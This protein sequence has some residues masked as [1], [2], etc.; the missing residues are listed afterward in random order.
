[1]KEAIETFLERQ[2]QYGEANYLK[3]GKVLAMLFPEGITAKGVEDM[4]RL[5]LFVMLVLKVTRYSENFDRGGHQDSVHDLGV[6]A[7]ILEA[8]DDQMRD[9]VDL[10]S[11]E[12]ITDPYWP[13]EET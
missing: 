4:N 2:K 13:V 9:S 12:L 7:F 6:Y 10:E 11:G 1:M 8:F 3:M 5:I